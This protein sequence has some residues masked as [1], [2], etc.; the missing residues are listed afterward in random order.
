MYTPSRSPSFVVLGALGLILS[1]GACK[2]DP[3]TPKLFD[4]EGAWSVVQYALDGGELREIDNN[5]R[6]DAFMLSFDPANRV[7][8]TAACVGPEGDDPS[9]STCL[10]TPNETEWACSCFAYDFVDQQMLWR[11][12]EA[13]DIPPDVSLSDSEMSADQGGGSGSGTG[14]GGGGDD[15]SKDTLINVA[16]IPD[17]NSTFNYRPLPLDVFGSDGETS[18][19]IFQARA[20]SIFDRAFDDPDGR[21]PCEPCFS[22]G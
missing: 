2:E 12:F 13:G 20:P 15:E 10:L 1:A 7:V 16:E 18:R 22:S 11:E 17:V 9:D 4:E 6:A 14:G 3:P 5:N 8:T 19:F 21:S